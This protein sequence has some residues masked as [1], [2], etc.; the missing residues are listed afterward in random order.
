MPNKIAFDIFYFRPLQPFLD[1]AAMA[2]FD[3]TFHY[4]S[5]PFNYYYRE[6]AKDA[7]L[8]NAR[9]ACRYARGCDI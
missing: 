3:D 2:S 8:Q 4:W 7:Y 1:I 5:P 6:Y 9:I